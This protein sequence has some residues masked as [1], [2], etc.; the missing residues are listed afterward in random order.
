MQLNI[1]KRGRCYVGLLL[2][3][4]AINSGMALAEVDADVVEADTETEAGAAVGK[5]PDSQQAEA[6]PSFDL[7]E[8]R[9][10]GNNLLEKKLVERTIYP[11][12]GLKKNMENVQKAREALEELY[13]VKGYNTVSVDVP[14]QEVKNGV[15]YLQVVEGKISRLRVK[16]SRYFSLG[17]IKEGVPELA[18]GRV[19]NMP[20]VQKQL[21][22]LA[23]ENPDRQI[24]PVLRAGV[25][26]GTMEVDL[27]VKD[28]LPLHGRVELNG[29]NTPTTSRLR[30]V[31]SLRYSN[32]WQAM[33]S[34]SVMYQTSPE[35]VNQV[36]VW[37]GTY[38]M[39][40]FSGNTKLAMYTVHSASNTLI[41]SGTTS[42]GKG[43][44]YGLRLVRQLDGLGDYLHSATIGVDYKDMLSEVNAVSSIFTPIAYTPF[45]AQYSGSV[46]G[47]AST[48][49]FDLGLHFSARGLGNEQ[50]QFV[51]TRFRGNANYLYLTGDLR[52]QH[53]LPLG[54]ELYTHVSGQVADSPLINYEQYFLGGASTV[55]GYYETQVLTDDGVLGSLELRSPHLAPLDWESVDKLTVLAFVDGAK[56]WLN[57]ALAPTPSQYTLSSAGF[58]LR[59]KLLK[60]YSG[61]LDVGFPFNSFAPRV[62]SGEPR[63]HFSVATDF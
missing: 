31:S 38:V 14:E 55:R 61:A 17:K 42:I 2:C 15:V 12:L 44:I 19:P 24:Q 11:H 26:P 16:D 59:F 25:E 50:A 47:K 53:E 22:E 9:V 43:H 37:A 23:A 27:K 36:D 33:H 28:E 48:T 7:L 63:L 51:N 52:Y 40:L 49:S 21:T 34:A 1:I 56:G 32:L 20:L 57:R 3:L 8:L 54:M 5:T 58:G 4:F 45:L 29:R 18:E 6:L 41:N 62:Q 10:K 13:H 39:P 46:H 35:D 60:S 30:L